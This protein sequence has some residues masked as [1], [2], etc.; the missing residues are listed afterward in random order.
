[1]RPAVS[2]L[3]LGYTLSAS[4]YDINRQQVTFLGPLPADETT[5]QG[6]VYVT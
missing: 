4:Q 1:M 3:P 2:D 6:V 5:T